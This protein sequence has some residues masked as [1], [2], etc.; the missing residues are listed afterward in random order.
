[1]QN[2]PKQET[3]FDILYG[4]YCQRMEF[5]PVEYEEVKRPWYF[6]PYKMREDI[7]FFLTLWLGF[8]VLALIYGK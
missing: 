1:M 4:W 6:M 8:M 5:N 2:E 7:K 3:R